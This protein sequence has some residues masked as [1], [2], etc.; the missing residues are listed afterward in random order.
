MQLR[1]TLLLKMA[2]LRGEKKEN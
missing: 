1:I 2:E